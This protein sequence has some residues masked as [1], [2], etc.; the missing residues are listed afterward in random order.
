MAFV[1]DGNLKKVIAVSFISCIMAPK[2]SQNYQK[3]P[4]LGFHVVSYLFQKKI[5]FL[6]GLSPGNSREFPE[7]FTS[8]LF[9][10]NFSISRE[11][12]GNFY[13]L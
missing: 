10:G 8:R 3:V 4:P 7:K 1:G 5:E 9:P 11:I 13:V 2:K 6:L 12:S